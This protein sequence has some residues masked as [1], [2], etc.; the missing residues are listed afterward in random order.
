MAASPL[1]PHL[2]GGLGRLN[3]LIGLL[4]ARPVEEEK[5][6]EP[7]R[8]HVIIAGLGLAG[9]QLAAS[10]RARGDPACFGNVT[11]LK[12][13]EHIGAPGARELVIAVNDT[14]AAMRAT[15]A[16]RRVAPKL[17]ITARTTYMVDVERL[18]ESGA[19]R[20]ISAEAAAA[21]EINRSVLARLDEDSSESAAEKA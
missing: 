11:S 5:A 6:S 16:A 15:R 14:E 8:D 12:L 20:V 1:G 21:G 2:A 13:L 17:F 4:E 19:N 3:P 7:L 10:L 18:I 9:V